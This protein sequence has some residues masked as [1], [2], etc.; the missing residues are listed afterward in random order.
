MANLHSR[1]IDDYHG[2]P[3][4]QVWKKRGSISQQ[5]LADYLRYELREYGN[6]VSILNASESTCDIGWP[7]D[8][9]AFSDLI[10]LYK[11][12]SDERCPICSR[13]AIPNYCVHCG[14]SIDL[15]CDYSEPIKVFRGDDK[16]RRPIYQLACYYTKEE[17]DGVCACGVSDT[18]DGI[19]TLMHNHIREFIW[20]DERDPFFHLPAPSTNS[21]P[22]LMEYEWDYARVKV[23]YVIELARV[24]LH[25]EEKTAG[26]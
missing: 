8:E 17:S 14:H 16:E 5:E 24:L 18:M 1:W 26:R 6:Y 25:G 11:Y 23:K 22:T 10:E 20:L 13:M 2:Q 7:V 21:L 3:V 19:M 12:D 4:L 9:S 15:A